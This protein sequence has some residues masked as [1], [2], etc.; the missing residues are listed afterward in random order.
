MIKAKSIF[1]VS[2][3]SYNNLGLYD[4]SL[5]SNI[6]SF[7]VKYFCN[8]LYAEDDLEIPTEKLYS[9]SNKTGVS[10]FL[11]YFKSQLRLFKICK[12]K[13]PR[14]IHFQWLKVPHVDYCLLR[15]LKKHSIH[16]TLT[17]H[18][19]LPHD[20]GTKY[21]KIYSK[22]YAIADT[23]IVHSKRTKKDLLNLFD[24]DESK[25]FVIPHG[26]LN[27]GK[28][29]S[30]D[31]INIEIDKVVNQY[32]LKDKMVFT[33]LGAINKYKGIDLIVDAWSK[34]EL[35]D[36]KNIKLIIAGKGFHEAIPKL[37]GFDNVVVENKFLSTLEFLAFLKISDYILLPYSKISQSGVLLTALYE[38][39]KVIVSDIGGLTDP[40]E[41][42]KVGYV[43]RNL[44][45]D[46]LCKLIMEACKSENN[47]P[48]D[49]IWK[50]VENHYSWY[51]IADQTQRLYSN[52]LDI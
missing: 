47:W 1:Y 4:Y 11:S 20:S 22:I 27:I 3:M 10:K 2:P 21:L 52:I 6:K 31:V 41:I 37:E 36:N 44:S 51:N 9:Y 12:E 7:E 5:L 29:V 23:L 13:E 42:G 26:V 40:F 48:S 18:N 32:N 30:E 45:S 25:I 16:I 19:I 15:K 14:I 50:K 38:N 35:A 33:V 46:E 39:K 43:L 17:V 24:L 28:K 34:K 49:E 8:E